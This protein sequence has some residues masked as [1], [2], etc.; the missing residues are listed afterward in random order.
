LKKKTFLAGQ[1]SFAFGCD[2][3]LIEIPSNNEK[4]TSDDT[5]DDS[6]LGASEC[7]RLKQSS[8][9]ESVNS[10]HCFSK[11]DKKLAK[12]LSLDETVKFSSTDQLSRDDQRS[13]SNSLNIAQTND[14]NDRNVNSEDQGCNVS[15][16]DP[17][18]GCYPDIRR[19]SD[20]LC[21]IKSLKENKRMFDEGRRF[22]DGTMHGII[23]TGSKKCTL[24]QK[25]RSFKRQSRVCDIT[26]TCHSD[27][28]LVR[29][30]ISN[31][32]VESIIDSERDVTDM[33]DSTQQLNVLE[34]FESIE[35]KNDPEIKADIS[36]SKEPNCTPSSL[37]IDVSTYTDKT[38]QFQT[39]EE[40]SA[41]SD[42]SCIEDQ[43]CCY[44]SKVCKN[45]KHNK[46]CPDCCCY[47]EKQR[48]LRRMEKIVEENKRLEDMLARNRREMTEI[49]D[50]LNNVL[51]VRMEPGF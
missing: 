34:S 22:S 48:Y 47:T 45:C 25:R 35:D 5:D 29:P 14:T 40:D 17:R 2:G 12:Q 13:S 33:T 37:K 41:S 50:M 28:S 44:K 10:E 23:D 42:H 21:D 26:A 31:A 24:M 15:N 27:A 8:S 51:S 38:E 30:N 4:I 11:G 1:K 36:T 19:A 9:E 16:T 43:T 46:K 3:N 39:I 7:I 49:R 20:G 6:A 18:H 32:I